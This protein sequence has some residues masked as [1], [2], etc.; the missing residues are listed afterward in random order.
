MNG[1][2]LNTILYR[3]LIR[4]PNGSELFW[5]LTWIANDLIE[6]Y[7]RRQPSFFDPETLISW[8]P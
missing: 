1:S 3:R 2:E 6:M 4:D 7:N 8:I 5:S